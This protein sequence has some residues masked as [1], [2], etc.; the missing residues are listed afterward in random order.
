MILF[1]QIVP[2]VHCLTHWPALWIENKQTKNAFLDEEIWPNY[3]LFAWTLN[4]S[5]LKG[6][7]NTQNIFAFGKSL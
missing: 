1:D 6:E 2:V 4:K 7:N 3:D 5:C